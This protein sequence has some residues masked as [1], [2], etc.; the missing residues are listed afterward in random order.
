MTGT[1]TTMAA[2]CAIIADVIGVDRVGPGDGFFE[3]GGDSVLAV[4]VVALAR[5]EGLVFSVRDLFD[6]QTPEALVAVID[7]HPA[8]AGASAA[9]AAE[10][11]GSAESPL[12]TYADGEFGE[13]EDDEADQQADWGDAEWETIT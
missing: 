11:G 6:H 9:V 5:E 10:A 13:F 3:V 2:L 1:V 7:D 8:E 4:R 12:L